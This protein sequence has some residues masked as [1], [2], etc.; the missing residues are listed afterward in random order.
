MT[1]P[2]EKG[3][4]N[5]SIAVL[6]QAELKEYD[7][8]PGHPCHGDRFGTF[9]QFLKKR[10]DASSH[11]EIKPAPAATTEDLELICDRDYIDFVREYFHAMAFGWVGYY[12]NVNRYLSVDNKPIGTPGEIEQ[13][14][15]LVI[16]QAKMAADLVQS[17]QYRKVISVGGGMHHAKR[18]FGEG[19]CIY[20]DVAF[21]A[22][23]LIEK[24]KLERVLVLDT[25]AHAGNGTAEYL[26]SNPKVLF[27]DI[28]QDPRT[29]YPGTGFVPDIGADDAKG[30]SIN[31]AMPVYAG[32]AS[33]LKAF[34][35][36]ILPVTR[37]FK[38]QI[39][40]RCGGSDPHFNDGLTYLG[41]TVAGF[42]MMGEKVREM[43]E[44]CDGRL[45]DLI[46]SGYNPQVLPY[47]WLSLLSGVTA[48]P[49]TVEEPV[50]VPSQ[51]EQDL[52]LPSTLEMLEEVKKFQRPYW[53][54]LE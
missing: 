53:K 2:D 38:P 42:K 29:I 32:N 14:A 44:V 5:M 41:M 43:S 10:L 9:I 19:F 20:N 49:V 27:I 36:I 48:W 28:H 7:F 50:P 22:L 35:E 45:I 17:G 47:V 11:Y 39:I 21:T 3:V 23:Y 12:E 4:G 40:I 52:V 13:A 51:F 18:R 37:E 8:G 6:Y 54:C 24:Y 26:R 46:F 25:D 16:G 31:L 30:K 34:D 1:V 15:R 33:Y